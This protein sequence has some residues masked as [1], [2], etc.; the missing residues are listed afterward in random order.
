MKKIW[1][2]RIALLFVLLGIGLNGCSDNPVVPDEEEIEATGIVILDSGTEIVRAE[3][4]VVT[5]SFAL[6]VGNLSPHYTLKFLDEEGNTFTI[7]EPDHSPGESIADPAV[8]EIVRDEP[9]D[10]NFHLR[11]LKEGATTLRLTIKHGGHDDFTSPNIPV[12]VTP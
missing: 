2:I 8:V 10:W 11:G 9:G 3:N 1:I 6:T 12:T 4:G 7:D 5:G